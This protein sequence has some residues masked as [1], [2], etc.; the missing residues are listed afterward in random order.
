MTTAFRINA[1]YSYWFCIS[2]FFYSFLSLFTLL[3]YFAP[4]IHNFQ[5]QQNPQLLIA[6]RIEKPIYD[7]PQMPC[8]PTPCGPN[9]QCR[10]VGNTA[11]CTCLATYVGRPPN[12]RPECTINSECAPNQAC[13]NELCKD[14]CIGSCG[15]S[16]ICNVVNHVPICTCDY[17]LTG[18]PF[19]GCYPIPSK[20]C[21]FLE[22]LD[23]FLV[24]KNSFEFYDILVA[25]SLT[26]H[27]ET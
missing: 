4:K 20:I 8:I 3:F 11:V 6:A 21:Y 15:I 12:C 24:L 10:E 26:N 23:D 22:Y 13:I 25:C 14:P 19:S 1:C 18:D 7:E 27:P 2:I 17:G 5:F 16:A 9:S